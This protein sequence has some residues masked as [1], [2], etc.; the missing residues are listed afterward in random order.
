MPTNGPDLLNKKLGKSHFSK[1]VL[2]YLKKCKFPML[3]LCTALQLH[4]AFETVIKSGSTVVT[5]LAKYNNGLKA[6]SSYV[7]N[8]PEEI[9][10]VRIA[11]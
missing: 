4:I 9:R 7:S 5:A 6:A 1:P 10:I 3:T 2:V 11:I 8:L